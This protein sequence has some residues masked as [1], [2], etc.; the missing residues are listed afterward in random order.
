[1]VN[2]SAGWDCVAGLSTSNMECLSLYASLS[3]LP[4]L[5]INYTGP[6]DILLANK[7]YTSVNN[8]TFILY[9][10]V[11]VRALTYTND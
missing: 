8:A 10:L 6:R 2:R 4:G 5:G 3:Q 9:A 1:V 7:Y 11:Y